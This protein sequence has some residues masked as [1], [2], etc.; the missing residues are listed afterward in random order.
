MGKEL[1]NKVREALEG[2]TKVLYSAVVLSDESHTKL[3]STLQ[4]QIPEGWKVFAHHMTVVFGKGLPEDLKQDLGQS[5]SL[6]AVEIG[7]SD[8]AIAVKI[9]GYPSNNDIPH[10]TVAVNTEAGGKP[11]DS[12]RIENWKPI[13]NINLIGI[14][15][16]VKAS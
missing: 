2:E 1:K 15:T 16:E 10:I 6:G 11:Y 3:V 13:P 5:V 9:L 8:M 7:L 12:N 14:V 4:S